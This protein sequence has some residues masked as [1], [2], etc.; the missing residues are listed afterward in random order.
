MRIG[1]ISLIVAATV[2]TNANSASRSSTSIDPSDQSHYDAQDLSTQEDNA[3]HKDDERTFLQKIMNVKSEDAGLKQALLSLPKKQLRLNEELGIQ[4]FKGLTEIDGMARTLNKV[5]RRDDALYDP[6]KKQI[7]ILVAV[8]NEIQV[9]RQLLKVKNPLSNGANHLWKMLFENKVGLSTDEVIKKLKGDKAQLDIDDFG[10]LYQYIKVAKPEEMKKFP[11]LV[12]NEF[13]GKD[14]EA[15]AFRFLF[16]I[17]VTS[18]LTLAMQK[19][20][21]RL[22]FIEANSVVRL[23]A[24]S[25]DKMLEKDNLGSLVGFIKVYNTMAKRG[26]DFETNKVNAAKLLEDNF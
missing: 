10:I 1:Y 24:K 23:L 7:D 8:F 22:Q 3:W 20:Y 17:P 2:V 11:K 6:T 25:R 21:I 5:A 13:K 9:A 18:E 14:A 15:N 26:S 19:Q 16:N 12:L 4:G